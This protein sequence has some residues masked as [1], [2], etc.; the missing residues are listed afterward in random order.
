M[1]NCNYCNNENSLNQI[2]C[3]CCI[4][5]INY[6]GLSYTI[7][8]ELK[9]MALVLVFCSLPWALFS[10]FMLLAMEHLHGLEAALAPVMFSYPFMCVA[11]YFL[12]AKYYKEKQ[13]KKARII[14]LSPIWFL[15]MLIIVMS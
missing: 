6:D 10:F 9:N 3:S 5:D 13:Y 8:L 11:M 4:Y 7:K 15:V 2:E 14:I 12:G 1:W